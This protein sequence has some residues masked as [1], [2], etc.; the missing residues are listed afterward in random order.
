MERRQ[1]LIDAAVAR[2]GLISTRRS[3]D[4]RDAPYE[5]NL[6]YFDALG[7]PGGMDPRLHARRFLATQALMLAMRGVPAVYF[8]SLVGAPNDM[9]GVR[10]SGQARRINR[11][12]FDRRELDKI[13]ADK[14][15]AQ[16]RVFDGYRHLLATR[17]EQPAFHPDA[18]QEVWRLPEPGLIAFVRT[19]IDARQRILVVANVSD[20][21]QVVHL[22]GEAPSQPTRDLLS[23][24]A[25]S[26]RA[27]VELAPARSRGWR[28]AAS[29]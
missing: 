3:A 22:G 16:K 5:L 10:E 15:A 18:A 21:R 9:D 24:L 27:D 12:K 11:R 26:P 1:R 28:K 23:H 8:H 14:H 2:G 25:V 13:L 4:G 19:S 17:V 6:S 20:H 7:E 29:L